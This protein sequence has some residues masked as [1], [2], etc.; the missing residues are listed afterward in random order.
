MGDP[1][2]CKSHHIGGIHE[3]QVGVA[4]P[5][6]YQGGRMALQESQQLIIAQYFKT[7]SLRVNGRKC[8][9]RDLD[10]RDRLACCQQH[11]RIELLRM[12]DRYNAYLFN[13]IRGCHGPM[14][15][16]RH[17]NSDDSKDQSAPDNLANLL[18]ASRSAQCVFQQ[19]SL[20]LSRGAL[21]Q[22]LLQ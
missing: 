16:K 9:R 11:T 1:L 17:R 3:Y 2:H 13:A 12:N 10:R 20:E 7:A 5:A 22:N 4:V 18:P 14:Q 15:K 8:K 6:S 21:L 19:R